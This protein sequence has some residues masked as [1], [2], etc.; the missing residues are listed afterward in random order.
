VNTIA[1]LPLQVLLVEDNPTDVLLLQD[2]LA[3]VPAMVCVVTPVARLAEGLTRLTERP[4]HVVLL[5][6]DLP[7]S[8]GVQTYSTMAGQARDVPIIVLTGIADE[9]LAVSALRA[10]AQDYLVRGH[11]DGPLLGCAIR[12]VIED[13]RTAE[14]L[15][16]SER[17]YRRLFE[18]AQD[19]ILL[20]ES[21]SGRITD[22]NPFLVTLLGRPYDDFLGKELWEIGVFDDIE[23]SQQAFAT[24]QR[25][26]YK[27][28]TKSFLTQ[29]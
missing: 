26:G 17:Q 19:G 23:A 4:F 14:A 11:V 13:Q 29:C 3:H 10:G 9:L 1:D 6:L 12:A 20:L 22:V 15:H 5:D 25:E 8:Q 27:Y 28:P 7:D 2:A 18:T 24:L 16:A 21:D